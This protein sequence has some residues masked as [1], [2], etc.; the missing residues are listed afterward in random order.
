MGFSPGRPYIKPLLRLIKSF[1][2]TG[3]PQQTGVARP[4]IAKFTFQQPTTITSTGKIIM[5]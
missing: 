3:H 5:F 1:I 4:K 2:K